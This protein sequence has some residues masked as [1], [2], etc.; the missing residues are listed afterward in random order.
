M[1]NNY[2]ILA[3]ISNT[4]AAE[5][6]DICM[7]SN[8]RSVI[9]M[10]CIRQKRK[11]KAKFDK[12]AYIRD[13]KAVSTTIQGDNAVADSSCDFTSEDYSAHIRETSGKVLPCSVDWF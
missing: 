10:A 3:H 8:T 1:P 7:S 2:G 12:E 9:V 11:I 6:L 5:R 13:I 4:T